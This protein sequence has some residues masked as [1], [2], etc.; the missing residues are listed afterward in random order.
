MIA[1]IPECEVGN[2]GFKGGSMKLLQNR[3][4]FALY[5]LSIFISLAF[6]YSY[7]SASVSYYPTNGWQISTPEA[8]GMHSKPIFEMMAA[9]KEKGYLIQNVSIVRNGYL[10]LDAYIYPFKDG[11]KHETYSVTKSVTAALIG[12][13]IDKGY[14]RDVNQ[15]ITELFPNKNISNLDKLVK[16]Q[17]II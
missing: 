16:S 4:Y 5:L 11:Q 6:F 9:I 14:L 7:V 17:K 8:Q 3:K 10:V 1:I 15:T 2:F 13:A 12:I